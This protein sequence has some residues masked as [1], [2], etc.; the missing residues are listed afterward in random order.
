MKERYA[1]LLGQS[2]VETHPLFIGLSLRCVGRV[3]GINRFVPGNCPGFFIALFQARPE[4]VHT[5][6]NPDSR[7]GI[8]Q[9]DL[10]EQLFGFNRVGHRPAVRSRDGE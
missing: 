8:Q 1:A 7:P 3:M 4:T 10:F 9:A 6:K 2:E 5:K